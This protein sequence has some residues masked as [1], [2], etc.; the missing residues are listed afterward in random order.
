MMQPWAKVWDVY[1]YKCRARI[2]RIDSMTIPIGY[3]G[4][5]RSHP[6]YGKHYDNVDV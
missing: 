6:D 5:P 4:V 2:N 3:V 1:D